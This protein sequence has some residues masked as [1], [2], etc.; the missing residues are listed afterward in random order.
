MNTISGGLFMCETPY[1]H[2]L[3]P[4]YG[5][6][7]RFY[8]HAHFRDEETEAYVRDVLLDTDML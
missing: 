7:V 3:I 4:H 8:N 5:L 6:E 1:L 2:D